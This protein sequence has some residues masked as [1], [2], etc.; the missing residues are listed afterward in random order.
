M[1]LIL[2]NRNCVLFV[3][4]TVN[5]LSIKVLL[6]QAP[7]TLWTRQ[8]GTAYDDYLLSIGPTPD[9]Q[10]IM[11]GMKWTST[12]YRAWLVKISPAGDTIWTKSYGLNNTFNIGYEVRTIPGGGYIIA[13]LTNPYN[14]NNCDLLMVKTDANGDTAWIRAFGGDSIDYGFSV[15]NTPDGGYIATGYTMSFGNGGYDL[16]LIKVDTLGNWQYAKTF[17][18]SFDEVG[19]SVRAT[20]DSGFIICGCNSSLSLTGMDGWLIKTD[21]QGDTIWTKTITHGFYDDLYAVRP[22]VDGGYI[23]TGWALVTDTLNL[24]LSLTR[25]DSSGN[26]IWSKLYDG[27]SD[28]MGFSVEPTTDGGFIVGGATYSTG[29]G[30]ENFWILK[31]DSLGDTIWTKKVGGWADEECH[32]VIPTADNGY[33]AA[34]ITESGGIYFNGWLVKL[35]WPSCTAEMSRPFFSGSCRIR[36]N[37][38]RLKPAFDLYLAEATAVSLKIYD[39]AG[40]LAAIPY[41]GRMTTGR[42]AVMGPDDLSAGVYFYCLET[43]TGKLT[44]KFVVTK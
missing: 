1:K 42:H 18:G 9:S 25:T 36:N 30:G 10:F 33:L 23:L 20:S 37:P 3:I 35:G 13:G 26:V 5:L 7:D 8:Y 34:G 11:T 38:V 39:A 29:S 17:G 43:S 2:I 44:G 6:S 15:D 19:Y 16:F 12:A 24:D 21:A 32:S 41:S 27:G 40:R 4:M 31:T 28:D 14:S 22:L